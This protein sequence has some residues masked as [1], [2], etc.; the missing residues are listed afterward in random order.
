MADVRPGALENRAKTA[1][2]CSQARVADLTGKWVG[3]P[4]HSRMGLRRAPARD[5]LLP[6]NRPRHPRRGSL[7]RAARLPPRGPRAAN[8]D[9]GLSLYL[10][11]QALYGGGGNRTPT[12]GMQNL[13]AP[14][15]TTP[16]GEIERVASRRPPARCPR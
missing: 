5:V 15:T 9:K 1:D 14:I 16:P 4:R 7:E 8:L 13:R 11:G 2:P 3:P 6:R 10:R 12:S